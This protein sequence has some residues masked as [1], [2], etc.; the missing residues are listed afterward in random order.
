MRSTYPVKMLGE[1]CDI[2][3]GGTPSKS[4]ASYYTGDIPWAT[5]RDMKEDL[6][7]KTEFRISKEAVKGS[8]TNVIPK[9]SIVIA[10][11]VGL[12]KVCILANDTAIN[13]DLKALIPKNAKQVDGRFLYYW[14]KSIANFLVSSGTGMTVHG[15]KVD[16]VKSLKIPLPELPEQQRIVALL[17]E[18]FAAIAKTKANAE[19]NLRN[20]REL[21]ENYLKKALT[22]KAD[23][24]SGGIEDYVKL[25]DYRGRTPEKTKSGVR[26]I[27][28]K[29]V[30]LGYIQKEPEEFI[31]SDNFESWMTRGIPNLGDVIFTTEAPLG[32]VAQIDTTEKLAFAQ[33]VIVMQ[34][35]VGILKQAFL[36]YLLMSS[37]VRQ[38]IMSKGTGATVIGIK[39]SLLKKIKIY[40][41]Q[42]LQEQVQII[43][44][45]DRLYSKSEELEEIYANKI[46]HLI[47]LQKTILQ[48]A[49]AGEL[50]TAKVLEIL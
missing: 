47:E 22:P 24:L 48:K 41:P 15:I 10:T 49:F 11:R 16:F 50:T 8:S 33:R 3:G 43:E 18:C 6:L 21:Y 27:T 29:N 4:N 46:T 23:W 31:A 1:V 44:T 35:K 38:E 12:G 40:F 45:L 9:S 2:I 42:S 17:D 14:L 26:L 39:S 7:D 5:V 37:S 19:Q 32:N 34:P 13:Q 20:A 25:I 28:A 30:K 36:K